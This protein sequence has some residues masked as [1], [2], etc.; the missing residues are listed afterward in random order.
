MDIPEEAKALVDKIRQYSRSQKELWQRIPLLALE[1]DGRTGFSVKYAGVWRQG[2][3]SLESSDEPMNGY[4]V[5]VDL[6]DGELI[7]PFFLSINKKR[8]ALEGKIIQM[9]FS[10]TEL[11]ASS[12]INLLKQEA[13]EPYEKNFKPEVQDAWR[14]KVRRELQL[15][16]VFTRK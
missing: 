4:R 3:W 7:D 1:A 9:G 6:D 11:D 16:E 13:L 10:I 8:P 2:Y 5:S 14:E 12:I 15:E